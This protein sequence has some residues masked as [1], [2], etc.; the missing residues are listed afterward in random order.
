MYLI[1]KNIRTLKLF[2][3]WT[4]WT[5]VF[6]NVGLKCVSLNSRNFG[7]DKIVNLCHEIAQGNGVFPKVS[8]NPRLCATERLNEQ[9]VIANTKRLP[10]RKTF[11][12]PRSTKRF[13]I[14]TTRKHYGDLIHQLLFWYEQ[15]CTILIKTNRQRKQNLGKILFRTNQFQ[16]F[17]SCGVIVYNNSIFFISRRIFII[18]IYLMSSFVFSFN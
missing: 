5:N 18:F 16:T 10:A 17:I 3:T 15:F 9:L 13:P 7:G 12:T 2:K 4:L 11:S 1:F 14:S 6:I 8:Y